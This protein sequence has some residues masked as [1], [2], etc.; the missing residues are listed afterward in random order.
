[1]EKDRENTCRPFID[2]MKTHLKLVQNVVFE[3][4]LS[5]M[6][7]QCLELQILFTLWSLALRVWT[8][9]LDYLSIGPLQRFHGLCVNQNLDFFAFSVS[10]FSVY[11]RWMLKCLFKTNLPSENWRR[12]FMLMFLCDLLLAFDFLLRGDPIVSLVCYLFV[13]L[14]T[15]SVFLEVGFFCL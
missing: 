12:G 4:S 3:M 11:H 8:H 9:F 10:S 5:P 13:Y 6:L 14:L 7:I 1:M 2:N 15:S